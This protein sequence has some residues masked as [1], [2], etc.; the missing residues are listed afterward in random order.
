VTAR[1][2][3]TSGWRRTYKTWQKLLPRLIL[4]LVAR[5]IESLASADVDVA[6]VESDRLVLRHAGQTQAFTMHTRSRPPR[7]SELGPPV[8]ADAMLVAPSLT[9][10]SEAKLRKLG[11]SWATDAGQLHLRFADRVVESAASVK[12]ARV[13]GQTMT[14]PLAA[15]GT[16]TF[17]VL[18]RL[19]LAPRWRQVQLAA[20]AG[21]TQARVSQILNML[22]GAGL[23]ARHSD[24][25]AITDWDRA[26]QVWL[27][28]YPGPRG[29]TTYWSG[30][31]DVWSNTLTALGGLPE[32]AVVSG[33]VAA[34]LL[35][36]W[37]QP[38]SATIYVP[39]MDDLSRT[40]LVPLT[41]PAD[42]T[43]AICV[44]GDRSVWP[45]ETITRT[46]RDRK[47]RV[48]D[49]LQVLGDVVSA[50]DADSASAG[51]HL[52]NWIRHEYDGR[53]DRG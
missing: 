3:I 1:P 27:S 35:A 42:G 14:M 4:T 21:L 44:P 24:G 41:M 43:V 23:A 30:L 49:P 5:W 39:A 25:W 6:S 18:R 19:L 53:I 11:W 13:P 29:V 48:A 20:A 9:A 47:I 22:T 10:S 36:P 2:K 12:T 17:A 46:F 45:I 37:R 15:R 52:T 8:A 26:L 28:S 40:G 32:E 16:G 33:D 31:D 38:R 51:E 7:V 50:D 34:D